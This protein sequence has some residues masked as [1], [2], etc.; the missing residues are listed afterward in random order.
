M[1]LEPGHLIGAYEIVGQLGRGGMGEVY[2]ARHTQLGMLA[3]I[4][5]VSDRL[6]SDPDATGR[7]KREARLASS[8]NHPSIVTIHD[9]GEIDGRTFIVMEFVDG[10][11]LSEHLAAGALDVR[12]AVDLAAHVADGL[13]AAHAAG[14]VHRD[15]KPQNIMVTR[16]GR[17]KIVDFGLSKVAPQPVGSED[18]THRL[19]DD[20]TTPH[21]V[22]G[23][24]GYMAPEQVGRHE[25]TFRTDQFAL[26]I[27]LY[28]MLTGRRAF[29]RDS[30]IQTMAA[31]EKEQPTPLTK[32]RPGL[33]PQLVAI[34]E[35]CLAKRPEDRYGSTHDLAHD[36]AAVR[37]QLARR[38]LVFPPLPVV[39]RWAGRGRPADCVGGGRGACLPEVARPSACARCGC[40]SAGRGAAVRLRNPNDQ[41][42][43][44]GLVETLTSSL[45]GLS[46]FDLKVRVVS[47][48]VA[49]RDMPV[50]KASPEAARRTVGA[51]VA[52]TGA[53][54]RRASGI[55]VTLTAVDAADPARRAC[56]HGLLAPR[57]SSAITD[58]RCPN[59][60]RIENKL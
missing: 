14:V 15:L 57:W 52:I 24:V 59:C 49:L 9:I 1:L 38:R 54:E 55:R 30:A 40:V 35:R 33:P 28:E 22:L 16:D 37:E 56:G 48:A 32:L 5:V 43:C 50:E 53:M 11:P 27:V 21:A 2:Q 45:A 8:L 47:Q 23:T 18:E 44:D 46:A 20:L 58:S 34:V 4:K 6:E 29:K 10:K 36:L 3:A 19:P 41:V 12:D 42:F 51:T 7:L 39:L 31:I 13:A 17:A 26:G 60:D 25:A